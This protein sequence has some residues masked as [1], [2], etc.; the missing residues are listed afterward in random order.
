[1]TTDPERSSLSQPATTPMWQAAIAAPPVSASVSTFSIGADGMLTLVATLSNGT[2]DDSIAVDPTGHYV[3]VGGSDNNTVSAFSIGANGVLTLIGTV[4]GQGEPSNVVVDRTGHFV[5]VT[6]NCS[7][8]SSD[9]LDRAGWC[10][11]LE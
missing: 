10:A 7:R 6:D 1:M 2:S 4:A 3:Y 9:I 11:H 8:Y 5:L